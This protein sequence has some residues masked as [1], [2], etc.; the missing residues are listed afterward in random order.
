MHEAGGAGPGPR[1][2]D[3]THSLCP[4]SQPGAGAEGARAGP[5]G[6]IRQHGAR[7]GPAAPLPRHPRHPGKNLPGPPARPTRAPR[8]PRACPCCPPLPRGRPSEGDSRIEL[9]R[10]GTCTPTCP[11]AEGLVSALSRCG[12]VLWTPAE[13]QHLILWAFWGRWAWTQDPTLPCGCS[14]VLCQLP[15][16][17]PQPLAVTGVATAP[18]SVLLCELGS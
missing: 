6:G 14:A 5:A 1:P 16:I 17:D 9:L 4:R 8:P 3:P 15:A 10:P 12:L 18:A 11:S 13:S 7:R 2:A